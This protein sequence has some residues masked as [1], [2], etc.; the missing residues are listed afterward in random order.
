MVSPTLLSI[1]LPISPLR[2]AGHYVHIKAESDKHVTNLDCA[3]RFGLVH[4]TKR[5]ACNRNLGKEVQSSISQ[6]T[7]FGG[8]N[9]ECHRI[10]YITSIIRINTLANGWRE[11]QSRTGNWG[12]VEGGRNVC[13]EVTW[14]GGYTSFLYR[15]SKH[16]LVVIMNITGKRQ[17]V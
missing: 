17:R 1:L 10:I 12:G 3:E 9:T 6:K 5:P 8:F 15:N 4:K 2:S 14:G 11:T 7:S 13:R 16:C